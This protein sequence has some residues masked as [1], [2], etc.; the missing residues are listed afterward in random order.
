MKK[1]LSKITTLL[2]TVIIAFTISACNKPNEIN[3]VAINSDGYLEIS[4]SNNTTKTTTVKTNSVSVDGLLIVDVDLNEN[5][6]LIIK[7][8]DDT[9][10]NAGVIG[11]VSQKKIDEV[12]LKKYIELILNS[13]NFSVTLH[14]IGDNNEK[15]L[16]VDFKCDN[17]IITHYHKPINLNRSYFL[18]NSK[19]II[20]VN[21]RNVKISSEEYNNLISTW[22]NGFGINYSNIKSDIESKYKDIIENNLIYENSKFS[23]KISLIFDK[24]NSFTIYIEDNELVLDITYNFENYIAKIF[25]VGT[26][27]VLPM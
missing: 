24:V 11:G 7:F 2:L 5:K 9:I 12:I 13:E 21:G 23:S 10:V 17:N 26:T 22:K 19:C 16:Y 3:D 25:D 18:E 8:D 20:S 4:Y 6:E 27:V 1:T 15:I 14:K